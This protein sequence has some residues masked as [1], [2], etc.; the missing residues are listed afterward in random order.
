MEGN[1]SYTAVSLFCSGGIGDLAAAALGI[2]VL[3]A[4]E[5]L[6]DRLDL[7]RH[8]FPQTQTIQG[9]VWSKQSEIVERAQSALRGRQLDFL[10]ATP[11]CQGMSS[12]GQGKLLN[13][14]RKG[15]KPKFDLR[16]QLIVPTIEIAKALQPRIMV[17]ENVPAM[18]N[19]IIEDPLGGTIR[20]L[21]FVAREMGPDYA[22][23]WGVVEFA[24]Y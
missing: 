13:G 23:R 24:D 7:Y 12:N 11:P 3:V 19:T 20:I 16:N 9:D 1:G 17:F 15:L 10:L 18:E 21:G 14:I 6:K 5:L 4:N 8:N 22:G 2:D